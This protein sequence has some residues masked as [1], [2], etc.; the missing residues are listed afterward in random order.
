LLLAA[1]L[2]ASM[3]FTGMAS[4]GVS[5]GSPGPNDFFLEIEASDKGHQADTDNNTSPTPVYNKTKHKLDKIDLYGWD[6]QENQSLIFAHYEKSSSLWQ[7]T[8]VPIAETEKNLLSVSLTGISI[9]RDSDDNFI[10][11]AGTQSIKLKEKDGTVKN[12]K[13]LKFLP[14]NR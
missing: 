10:Y 4:A 2:G 5:L 11:A 14:C 9:Y 8:Y 13:L 12:A 1:L 7:M 3:L 6:A